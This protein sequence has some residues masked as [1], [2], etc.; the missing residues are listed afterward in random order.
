MK[1]F[2]AQ[3]KGTTTLAADAVI[4]LKSGSF[5]GSFSGSVYGVNEGVEQFSASVDGRLDA[6]ESD[7]GS[8]SAKLSALESF[9]SSANT[10]L[11]NLEN[12]TGSLATTGSNTFFGTQT[13]SGSVYIAND[14][15]VQGSSSIQYITGS[16]VNIGTNIVQLNTANPS[17]RYAGL[18]IVDSGSIGGSGS[19]LYDSIQ[20]EFIFVH[21]GDG[22]NVTSSHFVL[23]PETYNDLGNETYIT[24]NRITKGTGKE[25]LVDSNIFDDGT[26]ICLSGNTIGTG[27]M[28]I[29]G[30]TTFSNCVGIGTLTPGAKLEIQSPRN[31]TL[32]RLT[33]TSGEN[34]DF[35]NCNIV[36]STDIL[37]IGA[38]GATANLNLK[39][40]GSIGIG[41]DNPEALLH[42]NKASVGGEGPFIFLDNSASS[43]LENKAGIRFATNAGATFAGYGSFIEA[44]NTNASNGAESLTFGTWDGGAR[45]ERLRIMSNGITCFSNTICTPTLVSCNGSTFFQRGA[46]V[47]NGLVISEQGGSITADKA[48]IIRTAGGTSEHLFITPGINASTN[49]CGY[50]RLGGDRNTCVGINAVPTD[51]LHILGADNGIT[52]CSAVANRPVL[53]FLNGANTMLKLS[54]NATYGAIA[55]CTGDLMY[56]YGSNIGIGQTT[57]SFGFEVYSSSQTAITSN[58]TFGANLNVIFNRDNTG[59]TRNCF[60]ILTDQ[61]A[62]YLRTLGSFPLVLNTNNQER[63]TIASNGISTFSCQVCVTQNLIIT[64]EGMFI[65]RPAV[66]SGEPYIFWQKDGVTRGSIYGADGTAGLRYFSDV[67][68]FYGNVVPDGNNTRC[69]GCSTVAWAHIYTNDLH[70]SNMTKCGGNDIDGTNGN[71]TIQEGAENL[72]IINNMNC[73]KF[74][75]KLEEII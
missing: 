74:R 45:A 59:G 8:Q 25:H 35:K 63:L 38:N 52:I 3:L 26:T 19:F 28:C 67:N 62:A 17:V 43:T 32:L 31:S 39:D 37:S 30:N 24:C 7:T 13:F 40:D 49:A 21:R 6:L 48:S 64:G 11:T 41:I 60:N 58:H 12:K 57:P 2:S 9:T 46:N 53:S 44:I 66:S 47:C 10:R 23:G 29:G 34:W 33:A 15:V 4:T 71:W 54:A 36:G 72:Y 75:I 18:S 68:I 14:L 65:N 50:I 20:D 16:S 73:K 42:L 5:T 27:T 1:I 55:S 56:F 70:L 69:L 22:T 51:I 61:N